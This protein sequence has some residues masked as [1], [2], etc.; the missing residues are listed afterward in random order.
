LSD[1]ERATPAAAGQAASDEGY[2]V[3][4]DVFEGPFDLLLQLISERKLDVSEVDLADITGDFIAHL[5]LDDPDDPAGLGA[6][7]L[8]TATHFLV[9]AATLIELKAARLLPTDDHGELEDL[10]AEARDVLYARLLEYQA[11]RDV[12][13]DLAARWEANAGF[14]GREVVLEPRFQGLTPDVD[15]DIDPRTLA[16]LAGL[17]LAS[18]PDE[19]V[20]TGHI[21]RELLS[22]RDAADRVLTRVPDVGQSES[23]RRLVSGLDRAERV[24]HFLALLELF[25]LGHVDLDQPD[26]RGDLRIRRLEGGGGLDGLDLDVSQ[27]PEE[28]AAEAGRPARDDRTGAPATLDHETVTS[29]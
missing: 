7:D 28:G 12:A 18:R 3:R 19:H 26:L 4:L 29:R 15:L 10:L 25:K 9:I 11:F 14:V 27:L 13:D 22:V 1:T 20:D 5:R 17:A 2:L 23:Y 21:R 8:D 6:L 24:V 16:G